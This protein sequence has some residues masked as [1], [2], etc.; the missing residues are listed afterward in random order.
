MVPTHSGDFT[1]MAPTLT[2]ATRVSKAIGKQS[3]VI[4]CHSIPNSEGDTGVSLDKVEYTAQRPHASH[5]PAQVSCSSVCCYS[6]D[7]HTFQLLLLL[8]IRDF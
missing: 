3:T 6:Q 4:S 5:P 2:S 1:T 8:Y 7:H